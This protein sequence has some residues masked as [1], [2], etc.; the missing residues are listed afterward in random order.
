MKA[1][2]RARSNIA[3]I[4][5]WG[6]ANSALNVP[7]VGSISVTL[8]ALWSETEVDFDETLASDTLSLNGEG[9]ADQLAR[10]TA[11]LDLLRARAGVECPARVVSHNN[12]PTGAFL[13]TGT[14]IVP[15]SDFTLLAK[16]TVHIEIDGLGTLTNCV[17]QG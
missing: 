15:D 3:L 5:Y 10:V 7:A 17:V 14:G 16:D 11:C 6:K 1:A 13:M 12:F 9:R 8:D 2:A 4:K